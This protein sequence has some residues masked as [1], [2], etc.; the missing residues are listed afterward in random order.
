MSEYYIVDMR[1][2]S[3]CPYITLWRPNN[4]GYCWPL[5]W[6][7]RYQEEAI[8]G[9]PGYYWLQEG[10]RFLRF[11]V[12]CDLVEQIAIPPARHMVD[13]DAG[14][15][16]PNTPAGRRYLVRKRLRLEVTA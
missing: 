6:A 13:G 1:R 5:V 10:R 2:D 14:P 11:P 4:A 16:I 3:G 8:C 9:K 15:V 12:R 7:G